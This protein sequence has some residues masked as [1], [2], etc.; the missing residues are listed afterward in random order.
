MPLTEAELKL[1]ICSSVAETLAKQANKLAPDIESRA[2]RALA[3]FFD[4]SNRRLTKLL[5]GC[6]KGEETTWLEMVD[7]TV[8]G[9]VPA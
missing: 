6:D 5:I 7:D 8:E 1:L 4:H 2:S 3:N 9:K